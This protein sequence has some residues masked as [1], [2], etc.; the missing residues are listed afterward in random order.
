MQYIGLS[1]RIDI[2]QFAPKA[3]A[4]GEYNRM[5]L[6]S[7]KLDNDIIALDQELPGMEDIIKHKSV[8]DQIAALRFVQINL[9][10]RHIALTCSQASKKSAEHLV[11]LPIAPFQRSKLG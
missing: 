9:I 6:A 7:N 10:S 11:R 1:K 2:H 5:T 8:S 3:E 4:A